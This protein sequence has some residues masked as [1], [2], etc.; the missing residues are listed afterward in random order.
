MA[1]PNN[2]INNFIL[3]SEDGC[4]YSGNKHENREKNLSL[5]LT[6]NNFNKQ[7]VATE[8]DLELVK[9]TKSIWDR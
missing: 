7:A 3:G 2:E 4:V 5:S 8:H 1:F 9:A 6:V